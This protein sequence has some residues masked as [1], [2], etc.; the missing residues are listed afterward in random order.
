MLHFELQ[1]YCIVYCFACQAL[2]VHHFAEENVNVSSLLFLLF[3]LFFFLLFSFVFT[4]WLFFE[5]I[6]VLCGPVPPLLPTTS[7]AI[8]VLSVSFGVCGRESED[9]T[10]DDCQLLWSVQL[11]WAAGWRSVG[12]LCGSSASA[13]SPPPS[14]LFCLA[15]CRFAQINIINCLVISLSSSLSVFLLAQNSKCFSSH[16][17]HSFPLF[18]LSYTKAQH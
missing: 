8:T 1:F 13:V 3:F 5:A 11:S 9:D 14:L 18:L 7:F 16:F 15:Q 6:P 17:S 10:D 2:S 12:S 4:W